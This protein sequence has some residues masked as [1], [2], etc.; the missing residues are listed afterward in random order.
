MK[1]L[2]IAV[3]GLGTVGVG[4]IKLLS[5]NAELITARTGATIKVVAVSSRD[6]NKDRGIDLSPFTWYGDAKDMAENADYDVLL[7]T[8]GG[9][10]GI[11]LDI[12]TI[13]LN[14]GRHVVTANKAML[15]H[16]GQSLAELSESKGV[17]L[18]YEAAVAGGIP[19]IK[20]VRESLAG[21]EI[22]SIRGI[23]NGTCNYI[24]TT[25]WQEGRSFADV[26]EDAQKLGYAEADPTAD[27]EGI[28]AAH[29]LALLASL[30]FGTKV[31]FD[32]VHI[33]GISKIQNIDQVAADA[34]GYSIKLLG[35]T[36]N[37][38][39]EIL[40]RVNPVLLPKHDSMYGVEGVFNAVSI[41]SDAAD[42][43]FLVGRGAGEKPTASAVVS[44]ICDI[45]KGFLSP[46]FG[47]SAQSL[48]AV[49]SQEG[50]TYVAPRYI[51]MRLQSDKTIDVRE[52]LSKHGIA[53]EKA[54]QSKNDDGSYWTVVLTNRVAESVVADMLQ[55]LEGLD[56]V[57]DTPYSMPIEN[58]V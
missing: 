18:G 56:E 48:H 50:S 51:R 1:T 4:V 20:A 35:I 38:G 3:A 34:L 12:V 26:L 49:P 28:D 29:K 57:V 32:G 22:T 53:L 55:E 36:R 23:L 21:N 43:T 24:L 27:V 44:D 39:K 6:K 58:Q 40:Q 13:A 10:H 17:S 11:A 14:K 5:E 54:W 15:A 52:T 46:I 16:H 9:S 37:L 7:E 45:A 42:E 25:M 47:A 8:V 31:N 2:N 30:G 33:E 41:H 19:V